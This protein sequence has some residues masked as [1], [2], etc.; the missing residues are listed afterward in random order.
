MEPTTTGI[1]SWQWIATIVVIIALIVVGVLVFGGKGETEPTDTSDNTP[2]T[3]DDV[4][5]SNRIVMSDQFPGNVVYL[6][7]VQVSEPSW[8]VIHA[9]N[10]G[11]PGKVIGSASFET[12]INPGKITLTQ[13]T[14]DGGTYYAVLYKG[15]GS[16]SFD[17]TKNA[18]VKDSNGNVVMKIFRASSSVNAGIKG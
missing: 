6:S 18:P 10:A 2:V 7:S 3:T 12:G 17:I 5:A 4:N 15:N 14:V 11:Q 16:S 9:D 1:K 13:S 8:V